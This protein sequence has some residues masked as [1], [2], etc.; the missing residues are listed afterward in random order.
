MEIVSSDGQDAQ[1]IA[2]DIPVTGGQGLYV[3]IAQGAAISRPSL[4]RLR[5]T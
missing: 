4:K 2:G 1:A 3:E 5:V